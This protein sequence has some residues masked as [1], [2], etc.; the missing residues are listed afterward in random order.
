MCPMSHAKGE[1]AARRQPGGGGPEAEQGAERRTLAGGHGF[2][3]LGRPVE[4]GASAPRD[5]GVVRVGG[6]TDPHGTNG[7][8]GLRQEPAI[9]PGAPCGIGHRHDGEV[10]DRGSGVVD[11]QHRRELREPVGQC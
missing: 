6:G 4:H 3:R 1:W 9:G 10:V 7:T 5:V 8:K 2:D 11:L